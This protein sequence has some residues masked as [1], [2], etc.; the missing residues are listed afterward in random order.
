MKTSKKIEAAQAQLNRLRDQ[1][2]TLS[3]KDDQTQD[4]IDLID[5]IPEE[6]ELTQ[7]EIERL[8][9]VERALA[10]QATDPD[11]TTTQRHHPDPEIIPPGRPFRLQPKKLEPVDFFI[12]AAVVAAI[13]KLTQKPA[14]HVMGRLYGSDEATGWVVRAVTN[15]ALTTVPGWAQELVQTATA[16]FLDTLK[17]DTVFPSLKSRGLFFTFGPGAG[18]IRVPGRTS[19]PT[20]AGAWVGEGQPIPVRRIGL[21]SALLTPKKLAVISTFSHELA[22]YST[23]SIETVIRDAMTSDTALVIDTYL[24]DDQPATAI[25]PAGLRNGVA[26]LTPSALPDKTQAMIADIKALIGAIIAVN[27]GRDVVVIMNTLQELGI[28]FAQSPAGFLFPTTGDAGRRF[29]VTFVSSSAVP[30]GMVVAVD[31]ADFASASGDAPDFNVS[32]QATIHEEDTA[33]L[34]IAAG[35]GP[36]V[37]NPTRSLWQTDTIGVRMRMPL[38]W[39]MR[40]PGMVSWMTGVTW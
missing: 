12:R 6:I 16:A 26:G 39:S 8:Q 2:T 38:N 30:V 10:I 1:L 32:D 25:R 28:N 27:G 40:R 23:P 21:T 14:E 5:R 3:D 15:P 24:L 29:N 11:P 34:P 19:T 31:A 22:D 36:T 37:A 18:T 7:A 9:R 20:L 13:S 33:P 35:A 4:D 17:P